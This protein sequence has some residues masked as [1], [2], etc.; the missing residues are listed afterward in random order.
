M[1]EVWKARFVKNDRIVAV[2]LLPQDMQDETVL[3]RFEREVGLLRDMRHPH[4]V[5]TF[6][7]MT[8][9]EKG[10]GNTANRRF[11]AMEYLTGGTLQDLL[12]R[13]ERLSPATV[14]QYA[15]QICAALAFAHDRG[16]IHRDLKPGN[17][18]LADDGALKLADF[19]L[20]AVREGNKLTA[21]GRTMGTFRYM[22]PE[23]IRGRPP[24]C[25]QTDLYALG[26]VLFELLTG[27]PPF[28]GATPAETLQMHLKK[29]APRV[30]SREPHCPPG[31]DALVAN[32]L[33]K[34]IED[35]PPNAV[36]VGVRLGGLDDQITLRTRPAATADVPP[37][38][39]PA[40]SADDDDLTAPPP[41]PPRPAAA[42]PDAWVKWTAVGALGL[43]AAL[44]P[45]AVSWREGS[46]AL[47]RAE[48]RW[49]TNLQQGSPADRAAAATTLGELGEDG[50]A[51]YAALRNALDGDED[52]LVRAAA[53][54]ALASFPSEQGEL[55]SVLTK[56]E[57]VEASERVRTAARSTR[58][59][60]EGDADVPGG[61]GS[62]LW[63]WVLGLLAALGAAFVAFKG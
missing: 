14:V 56:V 22:A 9:G 27:T 41:P 50:D 36:E 15:R 29:P 23:Q 61:R 39:R 31:L 7:G 45:L 3:A 57:R 63:A 8:D 6:G 51:N 30:V 19:G 42:R 55:A 62:T 48:G 47:D 20:A 44:L 17:F 26:V 35:R 21:E 11:Y 2:K 4:I 40:A 49:I 38:I 28:A 25:P 1:G 10:P 60:L 16:V 24:A 13:N 59:S 18:L 34:R 53:A 32:L 43:C 33:E 52:E 37:K 46:A 12:E 5:H 54:G 58:Q